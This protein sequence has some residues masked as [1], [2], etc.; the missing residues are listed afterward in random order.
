MKIALYSE[1]ARRNIV[2]GRTLVAKQGYSSTPE[3][4]RACR[5]EI[6]N[7]VEGGNPDLAQLIGFNDFFSM[8]ECRDFLFHVQEHRFTIPKIE[9]AL[10]DLKLKFLGFELSDQQAIA[11]FQTAH[12]EKTAM[13]SLPLW[14]EFETENPDTFIAMYQFWCRKIS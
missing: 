12:H 11:R 4:I 3:D 5:Q 6:I 7:S 8:R 2:R 10:R 13:T 9:T 1:I 14:H